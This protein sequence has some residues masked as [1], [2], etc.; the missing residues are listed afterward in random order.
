MGVCG[1]PLFKIVKELI[2]SVLEARRMPIRELEIDVC[3]LPATAI[4]ARSA[5]WTQ[6]F[7]KLLAQDKNSA[8]V[9]EFRTN[10]SMRRMMLPIRE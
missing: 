6:T 1:G 10:S 8:P 9:N 5:A 3:W 4:E 7:L 2:P